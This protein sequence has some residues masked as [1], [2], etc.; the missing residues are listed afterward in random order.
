[1]RIAR[2]RTWGILGLGLCAFLVPSIA[3][4]FD[5]D[6][7]ARATAGP[8]TL[9]P[10]SSLLASGADETSASDATAIAASKTRQRMKE[11]GA[12]LGGKIGGKHGARIG[13][14]LAGSKTS[15]RLAK[16]V[17]HHLMNHAMEKMGF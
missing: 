11:H 1:M 4:A 10:S 2:K 12:K 9:S 15:Q 6:T 3:L 8:D 14:H 7:H 16:G 17:G 13:K 5:V